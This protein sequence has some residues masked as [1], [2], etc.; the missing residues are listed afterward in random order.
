MVT[1]S[2]I[3]CLFTFWVQTLDGSREGVR[4]VN[5]INAFI[6]SLTNLVVHTCDGFF[7]KVC[8]IQMTLVWSTAW[9]N[10]FL[11]YLPEFFS[12]FSFLPSL[13]VI[14]VKLDITSVSVA[15][16]HAGCN[17]HYVIFIETHPLINYG[18]LVPF[19]Q[20]TVK[21]PFASQNIESVLCCMGNIEIML[22]IKPNLIFIH[23]V[24]GVWSN[25]L[26]HPFYPGTLFIKKV[27]MTPFLALHPLYCI[28]F[29]LHPF[30]FHKLL[31]LFLSHFP[32]RYGCTS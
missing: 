5:R 16:L 21:S 25:T 11:L 28:N 24:E 10:Y 17:G 3:I 15:V 20:L 23:C 8:S 4:G 13:L 2:N 32:C 9:V 7:L 12:S 1:L 31:H 29:A 27:K 18:I 14:W 30:Y 22:P 19:C 26:L 6:V